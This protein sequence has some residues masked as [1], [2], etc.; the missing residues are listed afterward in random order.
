MAGSC[1]ASTRTQ[2]HRVIQIWHTYVSFIQKKSLR[3]AGP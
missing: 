1:A 2:C 3:Q